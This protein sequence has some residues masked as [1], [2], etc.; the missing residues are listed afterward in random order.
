VT[1]QS[2]TPNPSQ[3]TGTVKIRASDNTVKEYSGIQHGSMVNPMP[4]S[5][6]GFDLRLDLSYFTVD[7]VNRVDYRKELNA[8]L[9]L[10]LALAAGDTLVSAISQIPAAKD[11]PTWL[12]T[13][14]AL[15]VVASPPVAGTFRP[16]IFGPAAGRDKQFNTSQLDFSVLKNLTPTAATPT[17]LMVEGL[18]PN[19]PRFEWASAFNGNQ[20][21]PTDNTADGNKQYGREIAGKFGKFG[22]WLNTNQPPAD[23]RL[24]AIQMVQT[25]L[26]IAPYL[27]YGGGLYHN[28]RHKCGRN[29]PLV[30]AAM[31]LNDSELKTLAANPDLFQEDQQTWI[32]AQRDVGRVVNNVYPGYPTPQSYKQEDVGIAEWGIRHRFEEFSDNRNINTGYRDV[33]SPAM[34][35]PWL[36]ADLMGARAVWN[37]PAGFA[38]MERWYG[39]N[40]NIDPFVA[41]MYRAYKK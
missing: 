27:K 38:Y 12:K 18:M 17:K 5:R 21:Q 9:S 13:V 10:P 26:D 2:I 40:G 15:T 8:A 16:S 33:V 30:F 41:E 34:M 23:K 39:L 20:F 29:L 3:S 11:E 31:M 19:L 28:S 32:I 35:G 6:N 14:C 1:I 36:A 25:G 22:L 4:A 37:H 7:E 24:I